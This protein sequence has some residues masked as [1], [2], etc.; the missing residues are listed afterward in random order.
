MPLSASALGASAAQMPMTAK[1][2]GHWLGRWDGSAGVRTVMVTVRGVVSA[3]IDGLALAAEGP[4]PVLKHSDVVPMYQADVYTHRA[5]D[6]TAVGCAPDA[7]ECQRDR[8]HESPP[9]REKALEAPTA[10]LHIRWAAAQA[11]WR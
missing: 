2:V 6:P 3:C 8:G 5:F 1:L 9:T 11:V 4:I 7:H 10:K